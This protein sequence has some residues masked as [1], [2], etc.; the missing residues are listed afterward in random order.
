VDRTRSGRTDFHARSLPATK[1]RSVSS[2]A[3]LR[4]ASCSTPPRSKSS[5]KT[6]KP[7]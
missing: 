1:P 3:A 5:R 4:C 7:C 2:M 6:A